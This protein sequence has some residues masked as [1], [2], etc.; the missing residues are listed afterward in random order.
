MVAVHYF[1]PFHLALKML[2]ACG[3][4]VIMEDVPNTDHFNVIE[5]LV[6]G[7]SPLTKVQHI[8]CKTFPVNQFFKYSGTSHKK[9][10]LSHDRAHY[11]IEI[12]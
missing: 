7:E 8:K 3:L 11:L 4:N 6:D 2:E 10:N 1:Y 5:Q 12:N 9:L